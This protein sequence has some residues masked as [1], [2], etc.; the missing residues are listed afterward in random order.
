MPTHISG[1][2]FYCGVMEFIGTGLD[3]PTAKQIAGI[4]K[5]LRQSA[6][7]LIRTLDYTHIYI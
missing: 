2:D 7:I 1:K 6:M 3:I 5:T 4:K